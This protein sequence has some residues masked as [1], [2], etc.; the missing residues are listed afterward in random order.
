MEE[1]KGADIS[2]AIEIIRIRLHKIIESEAQPEEQAP[3]LPAPPSPSTEE[4][5]QLLNYIVSAHKRVGTV[6]PRTPGLT[7]LPIQAFKKFLSRLLAWHTRPIVEFQDATIQHLQKTAEILTARE[8]RIAELEKKVGS[9]SDSLTSLRRQMEQNN[10]AQP[11]RS[12][13]AFEEIPARGKR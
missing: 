5:S 9:L 13:K 4:L 3:S 12:R 10:A 1:K 7:S 11:P 2:E 6:N 8:A